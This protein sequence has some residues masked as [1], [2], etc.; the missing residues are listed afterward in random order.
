MN[1]GE[2]SGCRKTAISVIAISWKIQRA[3]LEKC[4]LP[5]KSISHATTGGHD[6][7]SSEK[8]ANKRE[9]RMP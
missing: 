9:A 2:E 3:F 4:N 1:L 8:K 5:C 6:G 7:D